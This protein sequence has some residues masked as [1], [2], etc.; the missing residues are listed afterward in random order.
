MDAL[1]FPLW[2]YFGL[3]NHLGWPQAK[4]ILRK[5]LYVNA[6]LADVALRQIHRMGRVVGA[7]DPETALELI[8][9]AFRDRD[10]SS[11]MED[12]DRLLESAAAAQLPS[13]A[14]T[15]A[16][17]PWNALLSP[18]IRVHLV[19]TF[20]GG[21][22]FGLRQPE[23][24]IKDVDSDLVGARDNAS[25]WVARGLHVDPDNIPGSF[26]DELGQ[27][28][29]AIEEFEAAVGPMNSAPQELITFVRRFRRDI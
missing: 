7:G 26:D 16:D 23:R 28:S 14:S 20:V 2:Y 11:S 18:E 15:N 21:V 19:S 17:V 29:V 3:L 8:G 9:D 12:L 6:M 22:W 5:Q 4:G 24:V 27:A 25:S 1:P 13:F 10:W